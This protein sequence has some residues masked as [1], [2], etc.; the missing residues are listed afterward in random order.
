[1]DIGLRTEE[2]FRKKIL[3][4]NLSKIEIKDRLKNYIEGNQATGIR[5]QIY[6]RLTRIA[7]SKPSLNSLSTAVSN[8]N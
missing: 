7:A 8:L 4:P 2:D 3:E 5:N 1:M 6:A